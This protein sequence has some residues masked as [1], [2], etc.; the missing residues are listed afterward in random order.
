M[1]ENGTN[2]PRCGN[3]RFW[4]KAPANRMN[5]ADIRGDCRRF[6]PHATIIHVQTPQGL[7]AAGQSAAFPSL[8]ENFTHCGEYQPQVPKI[9]VS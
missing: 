6:P 1:S 4:V 9:E 5:I 7:Q 2:S 3:C 8:P